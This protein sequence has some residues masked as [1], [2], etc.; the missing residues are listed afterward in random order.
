MYKESFTEFF[1]DLYPAIVKHQT[2]RIIKKENS[3]TYF[4]ECELV[5][6]RSY[7]GMSEFKEYLLTNSEYA[8]DRYVRQAYDDAISVVES[9]EARF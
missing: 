7:R 3:V 4:K 8:V 1:V 6:S 2:S 9:Y 5:M